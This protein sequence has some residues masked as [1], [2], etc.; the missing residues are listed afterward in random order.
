MPEEIKR[1]R[2][3]WDNF[4]STVSKS[5]VDIRD[6]EYLTDVTLVAD[7][8]TQVSAHRL[9]LSTSS[10]YFKTIFK[11]NHN[12]SLSHLVLCLD[13]VD[14]ESLSHLLDYMYNGEV[15]MEEEKLE[16]FLKVA[17][18]FKLEGLCEEGDGKDIG[19]DVGD[20]AEVSLGT[21]DKQTTPLGD[22]TIKEEQV[23]EE[24]SKE[25]KNISFKK[26][27]RLKTMKG[28]DEQELDDMLNK[29]IERRPDDK[30][31]ECKLCGKTSTLSRNLKNHIET[32][33]EGLE[34]KCKLC[35]KKCKTRAMLKMHVFKY[36]KNKKPEGFDDIEKVLLHS[37]LETNQ[38]DKE[39]PN[40]N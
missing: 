18:R 13:M 2:L 34:F 24:E 20:F 22:E 35:E 32:H 37:F 39:S 31:Y 36:H 33:M 19:E 10:E 16:T 14:G 40:T 15:K 25:W 23:E 17:K 27:S 26:E 29:F 6:E 11:S 7:D 38:P 30:Q 3:S 28:K 4:H 9:V 5:F 12:Q 8:N 1:I 21:S